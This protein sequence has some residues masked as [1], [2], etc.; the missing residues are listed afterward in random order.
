MNNF[1]NNDQSYLNAYQEAEK[2]V[3]AKISFQWHLA[4]YLVV[5][6][7]LIGIYL[8]SS[9]DG[10]NWNWYYPWFVWTLGGWG[11]GLMFN[12]LGVYVF[13]DNQVTRQKMIDAEMQRMGVPNP[14]VVPTSG[15]TPADQI[16]SNPQPERPI[17]EPEL[18]DHK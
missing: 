2:R 1:N 3:K 4:S 12:F 10:G 15:Y 7:F 5:N 11:I 8:L 9:W 13:S 14:T 18:L 16:R 6:T 17:P